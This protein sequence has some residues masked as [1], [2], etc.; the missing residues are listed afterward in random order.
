MSPVATYPAPN[1]RKR[2]DEIHDIRDALLQPGCVTSGHGASL[3]VM[4]G[5]QVVCDEGGRQR[6][7][8]LGEGEEERNIEG[9]KNKG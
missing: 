4:R 7:R 3:Q 5:G 6:V 1:T 8:P 9:E 2:I